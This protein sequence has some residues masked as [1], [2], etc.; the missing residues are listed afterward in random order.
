MGGNT[1]QKNSVFGFFTQWKP[2]QVLIQ[3]YLF[4]TSRENA[5]AIWKEWI[6][7][8]KIK[9]TSTLNYFKIRNLLVCDHY[10]QISVFTC[11]GTSCNTLL[12]D[13]HLAVSKEKTT[14]IIA[15]LDLVSVQYDYACSTCGRKYKSSVKIRIDQVHSAANH[16]TIIKVKKEGSS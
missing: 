10:T 13:P 9:V 11:S 3:A 2:R 1:D 4:N 7:Y 14:V 5:F 6:L 15:L 16:I 12:K 8:F